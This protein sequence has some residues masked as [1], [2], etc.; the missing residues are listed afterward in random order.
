MKLK[1]VAKIATNMGDADFWITRKGSLENVGKP[2][3]SFD[4]EKIGIKVTRTDIFLPDHLF[5]VIE[6]LWARGSFK[7]LS[8]GT[9]NLVNIKV[10]DVANISLG[11]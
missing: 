3:K 5:Y 6:Y 11:V 9:T 4:A 10:E 2:V 7:Q 8:R 1:D